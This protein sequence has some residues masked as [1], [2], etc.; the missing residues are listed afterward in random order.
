V[1]QKRAP[2]CTTSSSFATNSQLSRGLN[3][4]LEI[5]HSGSFNE[6]G[7]RLFDAESARIPEVTV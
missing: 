2:N 1:E 5:D 7:K 4:N 6:S 3:Y